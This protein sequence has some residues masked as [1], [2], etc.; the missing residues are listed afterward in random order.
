[1]RIFVLFNL[2]PGVD[3]ADY[4]AWAKSTDLP[5]VRGLASVSSF[6]V[7]AVSGMLGS[8]GSAPYQFIEVVDIADMDQ[9]G[10]DIT[11]EVMRRVAA[12]FQ[13]IAVPQFLLSQS[14]E[15]S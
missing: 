14:V 4:L 7:F 10:L 8:D 6:E 9:F 1:M 13:A 2:K 11:Q 12:E 15:A 3:K 5:I